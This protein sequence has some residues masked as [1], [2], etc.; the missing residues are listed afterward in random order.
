MH[1]SES[2]SQLQINPETVIALVGGV[3]LVE[4]L[5]RYSGNLFF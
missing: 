1:F 5:L 4:L 2:A 3:I